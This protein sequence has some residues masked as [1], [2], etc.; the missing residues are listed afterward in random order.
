ML[1]I[2][3]YMSHVIWNI[4]KIIMGHLKILDYVSNSQNN[5]LYFEKRVDGHSS[6]SVSSKN[7][8]KQTRHHNEHN[9]CLRH[10]F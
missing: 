9:Y 7:I 6:S 2:K 8:K 4:M 1:S 5:V 10:N 3:S